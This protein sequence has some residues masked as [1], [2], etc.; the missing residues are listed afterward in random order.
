MKYYLLIITGVLLALAAEGQRKKVLV[1]HSYHQGLQWTDNV[2]RGIREGFAAFKDSVEI[3]YDYLDRKRNL[4]STYYERL[5]ELFSLKLKDETF[6]LVL[7]CDNDALQFVSTNRQ[8]YF[9]NVPVVF[10]GINNYKDT[11][12]AGQKNIT[13]LV[14]KPDV[15]ATLDLIIR[16]H[17]QVHD[18][19]IINDDKTTTALENKKL[20]MRVKPKYQETLEFHFWEDLRAQQIRDSLDRLGQGTAV[21]LLTF[22]KDSRGDFISYRENREF[23]PAN[24]ARP[25]YTLWKFFMDG[26]VIG[27]KIISGR[28]QGQRAARKAM[29]IFRGKPADSIPVNKSSLSRYIFD[30]KMLEQF[31]INRDALPDESVIIDKPESFYT[32]N[33]RLINTGLVILGIAII[34]ILIL[35]NAIIRRRRAEK[36]LLEKQKRLQRSYRYQ[37][38]MADIVA[39][40]NSTND[41]KKV[42]DRLLQIITMHYRT[43]KVAI[44]GFDNHERIAGIIASNISARGRGMEELRK[45]DYHKLNRII[46]EI[47]HKA[48]FVSDDLSNLS[49]EEREFYR[50]REIGAIAVFPIRIG[51]K[52][53][54]MAGFSQS[55]TYHWKER[56][57]NEIATI[58]RM[59]ANA[60]ERHEQMS[61]HL[62]AE[63][64]HSRAISMVEKSSRLASIGVMASGITHE[65]NQPLS[66]LRVTVDSMKFMEQRQPGQLPEFV[67]HKLDTML[68]GISRIDQ[69]VKHMRNFWVAP[70]RKD[71]GQ[72]VDLMQAVE[73]AFSLVKRQMADHG[74]EGKLKVPGREVLVHGS[75]IQLEQIIVNLVV[76]SIQALDKIESPDKKIWIEAALENECA[77]LIVS[78]NATGIPE[79]LGEKLFDP[80][81]STKK[82]NEGTGLGLAIVKTF[83]DKLNG[84]IYYHNNEAGGVTFTI[85]LCVNTDKQNN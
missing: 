59:I 56:E 71:E 8:A 5:E 68:Q 20:L 47:R 45:G 53:F 10:C 74:I 84:S 7:V 15:A 39:L 80:F 36:S 31:N 1:L 48:Y 64:K 57:I 6:D 37:K 42:T 14:E 16:H 30:Y 43:G 63:Q 21:L 32:I 49:E 44:Y 65:I 46:G 67:K 19:Y 81:Y 33:K 85:T 38:M 66:A 82:G 55:N 28:D 35:A 12:I 25:V 77:R 60:W 70:S 2:N 4:S 18:L 23:I 75:F 72:T 73:N 62:R 50:R 78:D 3:F 26:N 51:T 61:K 40:L 22:N 79:G 54:G 52:I 13:G 29:R 76:N 11:L 69:I 17:P 9:G 58:V 41:F 83:V 24:Y 27:G 34:I